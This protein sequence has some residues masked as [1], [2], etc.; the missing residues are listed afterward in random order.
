MS[1]QDYTDEELV[2]KYKES[3]NHQYLTELFTRH[4]DIIYRNALR[5]MKN[6]ADAEDIVQIAYI[7]MVTDLFNYKGTGSIIGWML[8]VVI[9][10]CYDRLRSEKSRV[11][12]DKKIMSERVQMTTPKN[13]ELTEII[14]AHLDKLPEI[15]KLP[16]TL[17]FMDGLTVKEVAD[18]LDIPEKTI[19]S[20]IARGL[21]KLKSS[22]Q[23]VGVTAS[24]ISVGEMIKEIQ[25]P[26]APEIFK[27]NHYFSSLY[28]SKAATSTKLAI[29]TGSKGFSTQSLLGVLLVATISVVGVWGWLQYSKQK[30]ELLPAIVTEISKVNTSAQ[31]SQKWDFE[32]LKDLEKYK[33]I[34]LITGKISIVKEIGVNGS[35]ALLAEEGSVFEVDISNFSLPIK[36]SYQTDV[37]INTKNPLLG[38]FQDVF[39]KNYKPGQK[40]Y[41]LYG[42]MEPIDVDPQ[43]SN[44]NFNIGYTGSWYLHESYVDEKCVDSW[45]HGKRSQYK[46][47]LS[48]D[49]SKI[50]IYIGEKSIIDDLKIE[51]IDKKDLH[52]TSIYRKVVEEVTYKSGV[53]N[54]NIDKSKIG[55][56]NIS[57]MQPTL[58]IKT[59]EN[60]EYFRSLRQEVSYPY[61][62]SLNKVEWLKEPQKLSKTWTFEKY[63]QLYDFKLING[64][65]LFVDGNGE[66]NTNCIGVGP[67]SV[68]EMDIS[69]F[70]L[71]LKI[72]FVF[73]II[74]PKGQ[75]SKGFVITKGGYQ[76]DKNIL[77][78]IKLHKSASIDVT[79]IN[80]R[81]AN[82]GLGFF[83]DWFPS[84]IYVTENCVD[85]WFYGNR[86]GVVFGTSTNNQK[87]YLNVKDRSLIDNFKIESIEENEAPDISS[88]KKYAEQIPFIKGIKDYYKLEAQKEPLNLEKNTQAEV[89]ICDYESLKKSL[90]LDKKFKVDAGAE[91][92]PLKKAYNPK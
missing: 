57:K 19:R 65:I 18:T 78:F 39:R 6:P 80:N 90:G 11:N 41:S 23:S 67:D 5:K 37:A 72:S 24:V 56:K 82:A 14:E 85:I 3:R 89:S 62:N 59:T 17:Q 51:S 77:S 33:N 58:A 91:N 60:F 10:T 43:K 25:Q 30:S 54:Y 13:N 73:D 1:I 29:A 22:L 66:N 34:S 28:Q 2:V 31:I 70:K 69:K 55:L 44:K 8:Q 9:F 7:K 47:G 32:D 15:Y 35:N 46:E 61:L 42:I 86:T 88:F 27:S 53:E 52:D 40:I 21:E 64:E 76:E 74:V 79:K 48:E 4:S 63:E 75:M 12:R 87:L 36:I 16:I 38:S 92:A 71:P 81:N 49:K 83:G 68:I 20:Q 45:F 50:L 26:M 84:Q